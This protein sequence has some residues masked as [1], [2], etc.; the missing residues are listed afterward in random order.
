MK[1]LKF[2]ILLLNAFCIGL[3]ATAFNN[4]LIIENAK[5]TYRHNHDTLLQS[6]GRF[7]LDD[8]GKSM[9]VIWKSA[10]HYY[11]QI[12]RSLLG[13]DL[14]V[15]CRIAK[16]AVGVRDQSFG[17]AGD[18][19]NR[20]LI[21]FDKG[22][23]GKIFLTGIIPNEI[24]TENNNDDLS[25]AIERSNQMPAILAFPEK[26]GVAKTPGEGP[27]IDVTD[28][29]TGDNDV[30]YF[31]KSSK[32]NLQLASLMPDRSYIQKIRTGPESIN[33]N[34]V[35]TFGR[36]T[37]GD[38]D[39]GYATIAV[40]T[41]FILL[42]KTPLKGCIADPRIGYFTT[43]FSDFDTSRNSL[44]AINLINRWRLEPRAGDSLKY[45]RGELVEPKKPII[46][47]IDPATPKKWVKY[48][49]AGVN[50]WQRAF[51]QAGFKNAIIGK[52]VTAS[53]TSWDLNSTAYNVLIY[54]P[55]PDRN[56]NGN[57]IVD[58]R[59]GEIIEARINWFHGIM[60]LLHDSYMIAMGATDPD[61]RTMH[62]N[63]ALMGQL[64]RGAVAHEIGHTLGLRH[65]FG[66]SSVVP[67]SKLRDPSFLHLYGTAP[68]IM[69]YARFN[70]VA[71]PGDHVPRQDVLPRLGAY[72]RWAIQWGYTWRP[73]KDMNQWSGQM[74]TDSLKK[75][76]QLFYGPDN[77]NNDPR[78]QNDDYGDDAVRA[79]TYVIK[80]LQREMPALLGWVK[81]SGGD[82]QDLGNLYNG[83]FDVYQQLM[84][85]AVKNI[86]GIMK[87]PKTISQDGVIIE[88][89]S[90]A[91]QQRCLDFLLRQLYTT[92]KWLINQ[93]YSAL[94]EV[95][96]YDKLF[97]IQQNLLNRLL[98]MYCLNKLNEIEAIKGS[99]AFTAADLLEQL[100]KGIWAELKDHQA[101]S[102]P[103]RNLQKL[104]VETT[105]NDI[106]QKITGPVTLNSLANNP[107]LKDYVSTLKQSLR[108]LRKEIKSALPRTKD[109][110]TR[111]HLADMYARLGGIYSND[112]GAGAL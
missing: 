52:E 17:F 104:Y 107:Q 26:T 67:V 51:E 19:L 80:N 16:G 112:A 72:D 14:L 70:G 97:A 57:F 74:I 59:S 90:K 68:S 3:H 4:H 12:P 61:A 2:S 47:Y 81:K 29:V 43:G 99:S 83:F 58:P 45:L 106:H 62:F 71:Q 37:S 75:D 38:V 60:G 53:D 77:D 82:Y 108:N 9:L 66:S 24:S 27:V 32:K 18:E 92:P 98:G 78:S 73:Q 50:D 10:D 102:L 91:R 23:E 41:S 55:S 93:R 33:I 89:T 46:F 64:I 76:P 44:T 65:N 111:A 35:K 56:A 100:Q 48:M 96:P 69:D 87:T 30:L 42:P 8:S 95:K 84:N 36:T 7:A 101:I 21:R 49:I 6:S 39:D 103:R 5:H 1:K 94:T 85:Q 22:P 34:A 110:N 11:C 28:L 13:R 31:S 54:E 105:L 25:R 88:Y 15:I 109:V 20:K 40:S 79:G 86:G 63:D